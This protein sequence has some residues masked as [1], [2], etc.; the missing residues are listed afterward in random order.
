MAKAIAPPPAKLCKNRFFGSVLLANHRL[1]GLNRWG[2]EMTVCWGNTKKTAI[3]GRSKIKKKVSGDLLS[4]DH[5]DSW[6]G[7][8]AGLAREGKK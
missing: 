2:V 5:L 6:L 1:S 3:S 4:E 7:I 8:E